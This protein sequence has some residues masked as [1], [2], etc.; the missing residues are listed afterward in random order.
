MIAITCRAWL[1]AWA[2][3][4]ATLATAQGVSSSVHIPSKSVSGR[5]SEPG[6]ESTITELPA[7]PTLTASPHFSASTPATPTENASP[8]SE[9]SP[10]LAPSLARVEHH[11]HPEWS[12]WL[13]L[14]DP[15]SNPL[16]A[17]GGLLALMAFMATLAYRRNQRFDAQARVDPPAPAP[18]GP[19]SPSA[20]RRSLQAEIMALDLELGPSDAPSEAP[21]PFAAPAPVTTPEATPVTHPVE[22]S[23][24]KLQWAQQLLAAGENELARVLLSSVAN[25]L[26]SQLQQRGHHTTGPRQ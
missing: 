25:T 17:A 1:T 7:A 4:V 18:A 13:K 21:S 15:G 20:D 8:S 11:P 2:L 14:L 26:H 16:A 6:S 12:A 24:Q 3:V 10:T 23:L 9:A 19:K 22:L 5:V